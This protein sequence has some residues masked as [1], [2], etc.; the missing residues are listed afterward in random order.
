MT[1]HEDLNQAIHT[2]TKTTYH[3]VK[4]LAANLGMTPTETT[5]M[6][7]ATIRDQVQHAHNQEP[8]RFHNALEPT[9]TCAYCPTTAKPT[10]NNKTPQ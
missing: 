1:N 4:N 10:T 6:I 2:G 7:A 8:D 3:A 9:E 5:R